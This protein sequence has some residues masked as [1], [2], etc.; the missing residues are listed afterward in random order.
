MDERH[1]YCPQ[2]PGSWCKYAVNKLNGKD[3]TYKP[4]V[5][6]PE[7]ISKMIKLIFSYKDLGSDELLQKCLHGSTQ[8]VSDSINNVIWQRCSDRVY[9]GL[10]S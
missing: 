7:E 6:I 10:H 9:V 4:K 5:S 1:Q 3:T 8:N 2:G